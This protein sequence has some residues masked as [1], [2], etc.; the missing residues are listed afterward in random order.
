MNTAG[1]GADLGR[2]GLR[3]GREWLVRGRGGRNIEGLVIIVREA[4]LGVVHSIRSKEF[5]GQLNRKL[6]GWVAGP[7]RL[8]R[9]PVIRNRHE[10]ENYVDSCSGRTKKGLNGGS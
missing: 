9:S 7:S 5:R 8:N 3:N 6:V 4:I 10:D 1:Q 2:L